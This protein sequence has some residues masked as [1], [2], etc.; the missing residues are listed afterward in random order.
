MLFGDILKEALKSINKNIKFGFI[1]G[2]FAIG[3]ES[4]NSDID[5]FVMGELGIR[6]IANILS[7]SGRKLGR[8]INPTVYSE[9]EFTKKIKEKNPFIKDILHRPKIWLIEMKMNLKKWINEGRLL[10]HSTNKNEIKNLFKLVDRDLKDAKIKQL[11]ADRRFATAY[12]A[13]LQLATIVLHAAGYRTKGG[14]GGHHWVTILS[15]PDVMEK[16]Q[17]TR[18]DYFDAC[19]AKRNVTDYDRVG[20]ISESDLKELLNEVLALSA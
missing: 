8:E 9:K 10:P 14:S 18:S 1:Y 6:D 4:S 20:E 17:K 12:N 3:K 15:L 13:A 16:I 5:M 2:S 19:R 7:K 11:S